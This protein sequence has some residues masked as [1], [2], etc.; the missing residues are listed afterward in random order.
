MEAKKLYT[1]LYSLLDNV[2]PLKTD[3]GALCD[4]A[5]CKGD[6]AGMYLFPYEEVMYTEKEKW[7]EIYESDI[8]LRG[9]PIKILVCKGRCDRKKRPLSC[10]IFPLFLNK[11]GEVSLDSRANAMCPLVQNKLSLDEYNPEFVENVGKVFKML[12]KIKITKE[13]IE[14]NREII[15]EYNEL[16]SLFSE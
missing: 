4:G 2:T 1:Y 3:C 8:L 6:D 15:D 16:K 11:D 9:E 12:K 5:C 13:F 7:M 14:L 10:R